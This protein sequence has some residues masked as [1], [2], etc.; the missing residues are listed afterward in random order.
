[1]VIDSNEA[2]FIR[3]QH[4]FAVM[5]RH[6]NCLNVLNLQKHG[7]EVFC[8]YIFWATPNINLPQFIACIW[9]N[10]THNMA[11]ND[12]NFFVFQSLYF[13][14]WSTWMAA[15]MLKILNWS[16]LVIQNW[17]MRF[18]IS[19]NE[20]WEWTTD[21]RFLVIF[22]SQSSI[23][24]QFLRIENTSGGYFYMIHIIIQMNVS[25]V[26]WIMSLPK[27]RSTESVC[28]HV[29]LTLCRQ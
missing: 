2:I 19:V 8:A 12:Y 18:S 20:N 10:E 14:N 11:T 21:G 6:W 4:M 27:N 16:F 13:Y 28:E 15:V 26:L 24:V 22:S 5:M 29:W 3:P 7:D 23:V 17:L 25:L 9:T 1:M